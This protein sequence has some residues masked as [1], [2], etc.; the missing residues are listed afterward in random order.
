MK[1]TKYYFSEKTV[2]RFAGRDDSLNSISIIKG[3]D[4]ESVTRD[5]E[6]KKWSIVYKNGDEK[7]ISYQ[8]F[9]KDMSNI[10]DN[11]DI[12]EVIDIDYI[13][14]VKLQKSKI[15]RSEGIVFT[16][17]EKFKSKINITNESKE[18][19]VNVTK[20]IGND[21]NRIYISFIP[22]NINKHRYTSSVS[23]LV[24]ALKDLLQIVDKYDSNKKE[25][26]LNVQY[27][28]YL[29]GI[30]DIKILSVKEL[31]ELDIESNRNFYDFKSFLLIP[32]YKHDLRLYDVSDKDV[33]ILKSNVEKLGILMEEYY[34]KKEI[35]TIV[36]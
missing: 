7:L 19:L 16:I 5:S 26:I 15:N 31:L 12:D 2:C 1:E 30:H 9:H 17:P 3:K 32:G 14:P 20:E 29:E 18:V 22:H 28:I 11:K 27:K 34:Y 24:A 8:D 35:A 25:T 6:N 21:H 36:K 13:V 23:T 10:I 4:I 33:E